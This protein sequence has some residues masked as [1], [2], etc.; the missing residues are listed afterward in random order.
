MKNMIRTEA[1]IIGLVA[2]LMWSLQG[3]L[4]VL[5]GAMPVFLL[6]GVSFLIGAVP[7]LFLWV[8]H[9]QSWRVLCQPF[10]VWLIGVGGLFAYHVFYFTAFALTAPSHQVEANLINYL[11]PV[12][13]VLGSAFMPG[14]RLRWYHILGVLLGFLGLFFIILSHGI[15]ID[16]AYLL[17]YLSAFVAAVLWAVYSLASRRVANVPTNI[18]AVFCLIV[19]ILSLFCHVIIGEETRW[20]TEMGQWISLILLGLF[21][22][23]GAFYCWDFGIKRGNIQLLGVASYAIPLLST[24]LLIVFGRGDMNWQVAVAC[25]LIVLGAVVAS[26]D[27]IFSRMRRKNPD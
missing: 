3:T 12:L 5:S 10:S 25:L 18:V 2:I 20:P 15:Q 7:G 4:T 17:G 11:W 19:G 8:K 6:T 13:I 24:L 14:E 26:K 21:P 16:S 27:I 1:T 23:G 9:P 22:L